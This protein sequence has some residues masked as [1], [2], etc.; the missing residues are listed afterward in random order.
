[1]RR[2]GR[3]VR[4]VNDMVTPMVCPRIIAQPVAPRLRRWVEGVVSAALLAAAT[5]MA[6]QPAYEHGISL[7]H[8][9]KYPADFEHFDYA[10]P[11]APKGGS[12]T[13][14]TTWPIRNFSGAWGT[15]VANA[16]GVERTMDRLFVR[17][18]DE[19]SA[20]YG[21]LVDGV[22][23]SADRKSLH[24]RLHEAA[25]WHDGVPVTTTD[26]SFSYDVMGATSLAG[27]I[28]L[29]SWVESIEI[30]NEREFVIHHRDVFTHSNLLALSTFPM[31]PAHYYANR[32]P[33]KV[34]LEPPL[35]GGPYRIAEF[36]RN[37][38]TYERVD[39]YWGRDLPVNRGR[40]NFG[41]IR[42]DVYRDATVAREAFRKGLLDVFW[43]TDVRYWNTSYDVPALRTGRLLKDTRRVGKSIGQEQALTFNLNR[44]IFR[45][46][47]VR[48]ALTLAFD[49]EWQNRVFH[50]G[51]QNR[52][53]SYFA[54]SSLAATG[55]PS[56]DE[57]ALLAPHRDRIP[58]RVFSEPFQL[59]VSVGQ[60]RHRV[61]LERA[62]NLLAD[63]GW[64]LV[65]GRLENAQGR[66]LT[67][68][69]ATQN[70]WAKRL[71]LP[72]V[73]SLATLG[74]EA[75]LRLLDNVTAVRFKRERRFDM[76]FRGL[77]FL[78]PPMSQLRGYFGSANAEVGMGGNLAGIRDPVVDDLIDRAMRAPDMESAAVV[79][80]ALDRVL[81]WGFYHIPLNMP[82]DERFLYWDKFGRADDSA[83]VFE[84]LEGGLARVIDSWWVKD[85]ERESP[86]RGA[87]PVMDRGRSSSD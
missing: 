58:E 31:R 64:T 80:R 82:A 54:G 33:G 6:G 28:Y 34:T 24:I 86:A 81:L 62:R 61:A 73:E 22:A 35:V 59:P 42:Y 74:I 36:D 50:Y 26:L 68:E 63:A 38:V 84:Y 78:N 10:N 4:R 27:E 52:A 51:S 77:D 12:V 71:L 66:P 46:P 65:D 85:I 1:M 44:E 18:A 21:L 75:S 45:D 29:R 83:A 23:L 17:S 40:H 2:E 69:V 32:D 25:R 30:V 19:P 11:H 14:S 37:H 72:Y 60:G 43:E 48:E 39:D 67:L 70:A 20:L 55:L 5:G 79:C 8:E 56:D 47:R 15:G 7:L 13:L 16:A 57:M 76:Y 87:V 49:F 53:L 41:T 9:L 3:V